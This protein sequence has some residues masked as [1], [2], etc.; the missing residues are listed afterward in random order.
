M[1]ADSSRPAAPPS[2]AEPIAAT[3]ERAAVG[4]AWHG[5]ALAQLVAG[6]SAAQAAA[7]PIAGAHSIWELVLHLA[8][9]AEIVRE[10]LTGDPGQPDP[11][12]NFPPVREATEAAWLDAVAHLE[13]SHHDLA[14]AAA[15][16]DDAAL[17]AT[18]PGRSYSVRTMLVGSAEHAAYHGGQIAL[19]RRAQGVEP[20]AS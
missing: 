12:R 16:L 6:L 18:V 4:P 2:A 11:A 19:L 17:G 3:I 13:R 7:H 20:P 15:S 8:S 14:R 5:P 10:R 1:T 9:W